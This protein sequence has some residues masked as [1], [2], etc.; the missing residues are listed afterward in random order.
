M[1]RWLKLRMIILLGCL[2]SLAFGDMN[3]QAAEPVWQ[4]EFAYEGFSCVPQLLSVK[5]SGEIIVI[6]TMLNQRDMDVAGRIWQWTLDK[7][8]GERL[9]DIT[10]KSGTPKDCGAI[11]SFW[12]RKGLDIISDDE[13]QL[14]VDYFDTDNKQRLI[15]NKDGLAVKKYET[16]TQAT[17]SDFQ[18]WR[19]K[20]INTKEYFLIGSEKKELNGVVQKRNNNGDVIW[21]KQYQYGDWSCIGDL[22]R[23]KN[24]DLSVFTGWTIN[25]GDK[26]CNAWVNIID[27]DGIVIAREELDVNSIDF[28]R[29][30]R[31]AV[32]DNDDIVVVYNRAFEGQPT[33]IEYRIYS[34]SLELK[35]KNSVYVSNDEI[36]YYG[37]ATIDGGF[38]VVHDI[39]KPDGGQDII[40]HQYDCGGKKIKT[41]KINGVGVLGD[42]IIVD[43][44]GKT[45]YIASLK[46]PVFPPLKTVITALNLDSSD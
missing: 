9:K 8:T 17:G 14:L 27:D 3:Y 7:E 36:F 18:A 35:L 42:Q 40:L 22:D 41:I 33:G 20:R 4:Q 11:N 2:S 44:K 34:A 1:N 13:I 28:I 24:Y 39:I 46:S 37:M 45:V 10:L 21:E 38:V 5:D 30:P 43:S 25:K 32:L 12:G 6:G 31:I 19:I 23:Y 29:V 15:R 26:N 16:K